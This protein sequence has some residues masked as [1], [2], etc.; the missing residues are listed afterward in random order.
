MIVSETDAKGRV[1]YANED[2]CE[3][4]GYSKDELIG[5]N[6]NMVRNSFMPKAAF[7]DLWETVQSGN[8]W[9]G[10]VVNSTK[11]GGYYWVNATVYPRKNLD[12]SIGYVS[13]RVKPTKDEI[14]F[15]LDT[16]PTLDAKMGI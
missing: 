1:V 12:G 16:Y 8:I 4:A 9:N 5:K 11:N 14:S 13:V 10:I 7:R 3:I 15:A 2:F 6:H